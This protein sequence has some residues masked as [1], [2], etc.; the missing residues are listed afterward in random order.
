MAEPLV[1]V[2]NLAV[3]LVAGQG[4]VTLVDDVSFAV[5]AGEVLC[6]VGESGLRQDGD[7][8]LHHR[9]QSQ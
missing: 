6:I 4:R 8:A 9:P 3:R 5:A 1:D 2:R 7:C